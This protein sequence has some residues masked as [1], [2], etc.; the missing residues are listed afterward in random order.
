[1]TKPLN[2]IVVLL[3]FLFAIAPAMAQK[4]QKTILVIVAHPD[5]ENMGGEILAKY[6]RLNYKIQVII[7]TDGKDGVRVTKI[8][9]GDS[10]GRLRQ[11]ESKC[12]CEKLG[13]DPPLFLSLDRMDTKIGV[14]AYLNAHKKFL[15]E[16]KKHIERIQPDMMITFGP[17]GEYGHSEHIVV[18]AAVTE[19]L[20]REGWVE[21]YP[22][23]FMVSTKEQVED[24]AD[25]SYVDK[26]YLEYAISFS[27]E[28]EKKSIEAAKCYVTQF[29]VEELREEEERKTKDLQNIVYYR[30]FKVVE[31]QKAKNDF[32]LK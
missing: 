19:L 10:L 17:D 13:I 25:L 23:Y 22:L 15:G 29:T 8:P 2:K 16:L 5:D 28:D 14:R 7:A 30:R 18:G 32:L 3:C 20:L 6:A 26:K 4:K 31:K 9:A 27:D 24:D 21:K 12:A 1:M 11:L